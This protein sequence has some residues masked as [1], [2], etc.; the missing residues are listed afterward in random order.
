MKI[1]VLI[2]NAGSGTNL[3]SIIDAV[4]FGKIKAEII[5]VISDKTD[6]PALGQARENNLTIVIC[7]K[8]EDLLALLE[9]LAPDYICLAGWKQIILDEVILAFPNKIL[10]L[11]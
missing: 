3:K 2:S 7:P 1:V 5:A 6:A 10:N 11:H 4:G 9:K 8:K